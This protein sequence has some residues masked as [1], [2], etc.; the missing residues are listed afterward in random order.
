MAR[1]VSNGDATATRRHQNL[2]FT[3]DACVHTV[4]IERAL[5]VVDVWSL[6][7]PHGGV[8]AWHDLRRHPFERFSYPVF[9][10]VRSF[11]M[12]LSNT[13]HSL[14]FR[15]RE[16]RAGDELSRQE[17]DAQRTRPTDG[18]KDWVHLCGTTSRYGKYNDITVIA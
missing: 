13:R 4:I 1:R 10:P 18:D 6:P 14:R 9:A 15:R 7:S 12:V 11:L 17:E 16:P 8:Q 2:P 5:C 3:K